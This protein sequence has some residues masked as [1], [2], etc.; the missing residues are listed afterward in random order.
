M[1]AR[2]EFGGGVMFGAI[3]NHVLEEMGDTALGLGFVEGTGVDLEAERGA[4][5]R[6]GVFEQSVAETVGQSAVAD[7]GI[8]LEVAR[9]VGERRDLRCG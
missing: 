6:L 3:E 1:H 2:H 4:V 8:G 5:L 9:G 7:G